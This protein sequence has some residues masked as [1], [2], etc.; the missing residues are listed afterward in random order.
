MDTNYNKL[1]WDAIGKFNR[2]SHPETTLERAQFHINNNNF[3]QAIL[4]LDFYIKNNPT[5]PIGYLLLGRSYYLSNDYVNAIRAFNKG[6]SVSTKEVHNEFLYD[7]AT[8]LW[9]TDKN[10]EALEITDK[11]LIQD[12][13]NIHGLLIKSQILFALHEYEKAFYYSVKVLELNNKIW[14]AW[15][16]RFNIDYCLEDFHRAISDFKKAQA[17][18]NDLPAREYT[19]YAASLL[20]NGEKEEAIKVFEKAMSLGDAEAKVFLEDLRKND[21]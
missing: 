13:D 19:I 12:R 11:I 4:D 16:T 1:D 3:Y 21:N 18:N 7:Y 5:L 9:Q 8:V 20:N 17:L 15:I 14:Q 2:E 6:V 10:T